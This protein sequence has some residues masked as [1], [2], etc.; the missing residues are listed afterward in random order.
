[1]AATRRRIGELFVQFGYVTREELDAAL[2]LQQQQIGRQLGEI[3]IDQGK[4]SRLDLASALFAQWDVGD[5]DSED[6]A[7]ASAQADGPSDGTAPA[8]RAE[9][10]PA[11]VLEHAPA[12]AHG[13]ANGT[14]V[15]TLEA[16]GRAR[17][18]ETEELLSRL[19][20]Q[21]KD[22]SARHKE[23]VRKSQDEVQQLRERL[24]RQEKELATQSAQA[25]AD[26]EGL[27][28]RIQE[29]LNR[30]Q[31]NLA[32]LGQGLR[33]RLDRQ[34]KEL[35]AHQEATTEAIRA[36]SA[37]APVDTGG[38]ERRIE[39]QLGQVQ[40]SVAELGQQVHELADRASTPGAEAE[41]EKKLSSQMTELGARHSAD[42]QKSLGEHQQLRDRLDRQE[43]ELSAQLAAMSDAILAASAQAPLETEVLV[44]LEE[45]LKEQVTELSARHSADMQ[46]SREE[47]Q[48]LRDRLERQ[49]KELSTQ[50]AAL[51]D[52]IQA[53]DAR[54]PVD[55][56]GLDQVRA[57]LA[58]L[59]QQVQA[60]AARQPSPE[61]E[62]EVE[63]KLSTQLTELNA[64]RAADLRKSQDD[65]QRL[66]DR[67]DRQERELSAQQAAMTDAVRV[68]SAEA[69]VDVEGLE[70]R[71]QDQLGQVQANLTQ[72]AQQV[73]ALEDRESA[74]QA[75]AVVENELSSQL[76]ELIARYSADVKT[77]KD[78]FL[79]LRERLD[80]QEK[81][82]STQQAA[83]KDAIRAAGAQG[84]VDIEGIELRFQGRL[85]QVQ[86]NLTELRQ[87]LQALADRKKKEKKKKKKKD[88]R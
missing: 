9:G 45:T 29:Q 57:N 18:S 30:A 25:P 40:A 10:P 32:E 67:L 81:E 34:E 54:S 16:N 42:M 51:T 66:Q 1:L 2:E 36:A 78:A 75:E 5:S 53:A 13:A 56:N 23:D 65:F 74:P 20:S 47:H 19:K 63:K 46:K 87:Q 77:S 44:R 85:G 39:E 71:I 61:A 84:P 55:T 7:P 82:L 15:A 64:R 38:L 41:V 83:V 50:Q 76:T 4:L 11:A 24:D 88:P 80:R 28:R 3:L 27:E 8:G 73:Q 12:P 6:A 26:T 14:K 70:R 37:Q 58:E 79:Q 48:Q 86:A 49:E 68:A 52:A 33:E 17:H 22:L 31:A 62:A 59:R 69:P 35:S 72:L 43:Q 21:L 60:L